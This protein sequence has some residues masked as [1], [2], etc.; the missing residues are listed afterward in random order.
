[1]RELGTHV[2][3]GA[4][5]LHEALVDQG[6]PVIPIPMLDYAQCKMMTA[7]SSFA[8]RLNINRRIYQRGYL[9]DSP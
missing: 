8:Q 3:F 6:F 4:V 5:T 2:V 7:N 1:L 9:E